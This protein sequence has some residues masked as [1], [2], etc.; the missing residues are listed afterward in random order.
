MA[1]RERPALTDRPP[2]RE[3]SAAAFIYFDAVPTFG[4]LSG[5][6]QIELTC[7]VLEPN[8]RGGVDVHFLSTGHL[9]CTPA[10]AVQL[11]DALNKTLEMISQPQEAPGTQGLLN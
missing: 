11:R 4:V 1:E 9:R 2:F 8:D 7:R 10:A 3:N 5:A 6:I